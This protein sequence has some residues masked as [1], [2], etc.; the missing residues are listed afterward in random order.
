MGTNFSKSIEEKSVNLHE[1]K[2]L[3]SIGKGA[4]GKVRVVQHKK[5]GKMFA[6]KY[7]NKFKCI[8]MDAV[9]YIL[10]ER[11]LLEE[12]D[13]PYVCNLLFSF[14]TQFN[15]FMVLD[16]MLGG[17]LRFHIERRRF[18]EVVVRHWIAEIACGLAYLHNIGIV[19]RDI[20][21]ENILMDING[22]VALTDFNV[23]TKLDPNEKCQNLAGTIGYL[24]P[25]VIIGNGYS[26]EV[27]W[28]S[29][30]V[31][32]YECI[33]NTRPF[34]GETANEVCHATL[35]K[36]INYPTWKGSRISQDCIDVMSGFLERDPSKRLCSGPKKL[37]QLKSTEFFSIIDWDLLKLKLVRC[38]YVPDKNTSNFDI[39]HEI[40]EVINEDANV[41]ESLDKK[42]LDANYFKQESKIRRN[43]LTFDYFEY[44]HF[45]GFIEQAATNPAA[46][47][48]RAAP[49]RLGAWTSLETF[50]A[51][52]KNLRVNS[53]G[54]RKTT[55]FSDFGNTTRHS[56]NGLMSGKGKKKNSVGASIN[57][58]L[59]LKKNYN[60]KGA[61]PT[62]MSNYKYKT[63][64]T[65]NVK[66]DSKNQSKPLPKHIRLD[67][68]PIG[69]ACEKFFSE[70]PS[71]K[72]YF[73]KPE[74]NNLERPKI[75]ALTVNSTKSEKTNDI[76]SRLDEPGR[77]YAFVRSLSEE[78]RSPIFGKNNIYSENKPS[79]KVLS[80]SPIPIDWTNLAN[81]E[82][83][84]A[85]RYSKKIENSLLSDKEFNASS[86]NDS[87]SIISSIYPEL[88]M[89][90]MD[91]E[92]VE[93]FLEDFHNFKSVMKD[94]SS[95][96]FELS[97]DRSKHKLVYSNY[98]FTTP[99]SPADSG[100]L[101]AEALSPNHPSEE[102]STNSLQASSSARPRSKSLSTSPFQP[103]FINETHESRPKNLLSPKEKV[104][105]ADKKYPGNLEIDHNWRFPGENT[106]LDAHP[107]PVTEMNKNHYEH[108]ENNNSNLGFFS[109]LSRTKSEDLGSLEA[110][111]IK[112]KILERC[113]AS[114][115][116]HPNNS[117][118]S[119]D[120]SFLNKK[121]NTSVTG[122][123]KT[124]S[125]KEEEKAVLHRSLSDVD[126]SEYFQSAN[127]SKNSFSS[128]S[129][130]LSTDSD[131]EDS[132]KQK[133]NIYSR[134]SNGLVY[135]KNLKIFLGI[136]SSGNGVGSSP[137][138]SALNIS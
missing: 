6:M 24:A 25:E 33:Y 38:P 46:D 100:V 138:L 115:N 109:N 60:T 121:F 13:H 101:N 3:K 19:H 90:E 48:N 65:K 96:K 78:P 53:K 107:N 4:Y 41:V 106:H 120:T 110:F 102:L 104:L 5:S 135:R 99:Y 84:L 32:M 34:T 85:L 118:S 119:R 64:Y 11:D 14:Q 77:N 76:L 58:D 131:L 126:V 89:I 37:D 12:I 88:S 128:W 20:K 129:S 55:T 2:L 91:K 47:M 67:L 7:I 26:R 15:M 50:V 113:Q 43:F 30:G 75:P 94:F 69:A 79:Q 124:S 31:V 57:S 87:E 1:F 62:L 52:E 83:Q 8:Q 27:D 81:E 74:S 16:L 112:A 80:N 45:K 61:N 70:E 123:E 56:L 82:K 44:Q 68:H 127:L 71:S 134:N 114:K 130:W 66:S 95:D 103:V 18:D 136:D 125:E 9:D 29:L 23:A 36:S 108:V 73:D 59:F 54:P 116:K 132:S 40:E 117:D 98:R 39:I 97:G 49:K 93:R 72:T 22:H 111:T 42:K 63:E 21:P 133:S 35:H 105:G 28:W 92:N 17:D 10:R 86:E 122:D 51:G 137:N